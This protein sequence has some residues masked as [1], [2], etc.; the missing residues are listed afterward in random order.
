M[1]NISVGV[2][3]GLRVLIIRGDKRLRQ[4]SEKIVHLYSIPVT[5]FQSISSIEQICF[6]L[7]PINF[8]SVSN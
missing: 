2:V 4:L 7:N 3:S 5:Y 8:F 6:H 1:C